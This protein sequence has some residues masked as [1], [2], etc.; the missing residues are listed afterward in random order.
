MPRVALLYSR[1]PH[2]RMA[3][4]QLRES[5]PDA[6]LYLFAPTGFPGEI[7][8][9]ADYHVPVPPSKGLIDAWRLLF[10]IRRYRPDHF[11]VMFPSPR[12][13]LFAYLAGARH[14]WVMPPDVL[15]RP[16]DARPFRDILSALRDRVRGELTYRRIRREIQ[17]AGDDRP[18][19]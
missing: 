19:H 9:L 18:N 12:L 4:R 5:F 8:A 3:L 6:E 16:L 14:R 1:G 7:A 13:T 10:Q 11:V 17:K 15:L 2:I